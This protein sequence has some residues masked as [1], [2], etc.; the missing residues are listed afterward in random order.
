[1]TLNLW[2]TIETSWRSR[3][4]SRFVADLYVVNTKEEKSN[5]M[6]LRSGRRN[7]SYHS[8]SFILCLRRHA[9][10]SKL[11]PDFDICA[12]HMNAINFTTNPTNMTYN[13][14]PLPTRFSHAAS[15]NRFLLILRSFYVNLS[16]SSQTH[17]A[18]SY[19]VKKLCCEDG[20]RL[21]VSDSNQFG[22]WANFEPLW[23]D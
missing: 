4:I 23:V 13:N 11:L 10:T 8:F 22:G 6:E 16:Y 14:T 9:T 19:T 18:S 3:Q 7:R 12:G 17:V 1:M 5:A 2:E 20:W 21:L 15:C